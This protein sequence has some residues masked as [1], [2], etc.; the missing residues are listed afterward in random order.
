MKMTKSV[1]AALI[2]SGA[3]LI[4]FPAMGQD[5]EN[6]PSLKDLAFLIGDW[7][8]ETSYANGAKAT[9]TRSCAYALRDTRIRC[10]TGSLFSDGSA[11]DL[12]VFYSYSANGEKFAE[13]TVYQRPI[14]N[15]VADLILDKEAGTMMSRGYIYGGDGTN[16]PRVS[17]EWSMD[18]DT[19][20]MT[21]RLNRGGQ[22]AHVW[23]VF[24]EEKMTRKK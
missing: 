24:I 4:P 9:G 11:R 17:E 13:V 19:I 1:T 5:A 14:G 15:K 3:T 23:P 8:L 10:V 18:G 12:E 7:S 16:G 2:I 20:T 22:P 21:M 6:T